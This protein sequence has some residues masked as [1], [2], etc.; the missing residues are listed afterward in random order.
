MK[1]EH[2][3]ER[4]RKAMDIID[5]SI[6]N[7]I[8]HSVGTDIKKELFYTLQYIVCHGQCTNTEIAK[9]FEVGK[10]TITAQINRLYEQD[11]VVK[12]RNDKDR[13]TVY[14]SAT[15]KGIKLFQSIQ[16]EIYELI[17]ERLASVTEEEVA[18]FI[19]SLEKLSDLLENPETFRK[20]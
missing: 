16:Q 13:R 4:Y 20:K 19:A 2:V 12:T 11:L 9:A 18:V 6:S 10:S 7:F 1:I 15:P 17:A 8:K 3:I 5:R 14:L